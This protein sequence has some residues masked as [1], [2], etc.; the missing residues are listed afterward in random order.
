MF[1]N[2]I[3][4]CSYGEDNTASVKVIE[5]NGGVMESITDDPELAVRKRR[6]WIDVKAQQF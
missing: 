3:V 6:Y 2:N 1:P 4:E 5:C